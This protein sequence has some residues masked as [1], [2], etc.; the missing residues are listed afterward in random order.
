MHTIMVLNAKG[1]CGKTTIATAVAC[2]FAQSGFS[3]TLMDFDPQGSSA[4]W[5]DTRA[6]D[7]PQIRSINAVRPKTGLTRSYQLYSG[8]E[9]EVVII[10]TPAGVHG[11]HLMDLY[12]RADTI[13]IPVMPSI[14]DLHAGESFFEE[15]SRLFKRS[16][17]G[18]RIGVI[19]NRVRLKTR[20]LESI[21]RLVMEAG[22]PMVGTLR[23]TQ[24]Y[25]VAMEAGLGISELRT[26]GSIKDR[27]HWQP[28]I[29]W[30]FQE[31]PRKTPELP[32]VDSEADK[33]QGS[34]P[35]P[36][37]YAVN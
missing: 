36:A 8:A 5:L 21:E 32:L 24:N 20:S 37:K 22:F 12:R 26:G 23:D 2:Y 31:I 6:K 17:H 34:K 1:G 19:A 33:W 27:K 30:L 35:S 15:M 11:G 28:I 16:S 18:K 7:L 13:L 9:A 10:D 29:D 4:R 25:A 3:T 14:I